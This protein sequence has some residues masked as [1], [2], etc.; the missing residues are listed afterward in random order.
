M[1]A[2][3]HDEATV[4]LLTSKDLHA[5]LGTLSIK[6]LKVQDNQ[7][8][9]NVD[10]RP[11]IALPTNC[12]SPTFHAEKLVES[13][14]SF[15]QTQQ[16]T[17]VAS[18]K[19]NNAVVPMTESKVSHSEEVRFLNEQQEKLALANANVKAYLNACVSIGMLNRGQT[20]LQNLR[21]LNAQISNNLRIK[22]I[23]PYLI[24]MSGFAAKGKWLKLIEICKLLHEDNVAFTP[25]VYANI[26]ECH[27]RC[28]ETED[29]N[30]TFQFYLQKAFKEVRRGNR[31]HKINCSN[32]IFFQTGNISKRY[33]G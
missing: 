16:T 9:S 33:N 23:E 11:L 8:N 21:R 29:E 7:K 17:E 13:F 28:S 31:M 5:L 15:L 14:N 4:K 24:L 30:T 20:A 6:Q 19:H 3:K 12:S 22:D 1:T 10:E 27:S 18:D 32:N 25:Q 2:F 26:C